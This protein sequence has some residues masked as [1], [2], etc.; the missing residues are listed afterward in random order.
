MK[1]LLRFLTGTLAAV[2]IILGLNKMTVYAQGEW[3]APV[4]TN[5]GTAEATW[6]VAE[7]V[8]NY[9]R[10]YLVLYDNGVRISSVQYSPK[11]EHFSHSVNDGKISFA[12]G[13]DIKRSG[14]YTLQII[15]QNMQDNGQYVDADASSLVS[16][17]FNYTAPSARLSTPVNLR[18]EDTRSSNPNNNAA[19]ATMCCDSV[20]G[21]TDYYFD[22]FI[23]G[24]KK[25][26]FMGERDYT[27]NSSLGLPRHAVGNYIGDLSEHEY[28]FRVYAVSGDITVCQHSEYSEISIPFGSSD[29]VRSAEQELSDLS[30]DVTVDTVDNVVE[31]VKAIEDLQIALQTSNEAV[32]DLENIEGKYKDA[33][34]ITE[35]APVSNFEGISAAGIEVTGAALN[36]SANTQLGLKIDAPSSYPVLDTDIYKN[37]IVFDM[38]IETTD[39]TDFSR[40]LAI[41]VTIKLPFPEGHNPENF[42]VLHFKA[43]GTFE[44]ITPRIE[45]GFVYIT[46]T[47]FSQFAFTN[48]N[49]KSAPALETVMMYRLYNPNSGE[50]F[51]TGSV[52]ERDYLVSLGWNFEGNAW[53]A[54]VT[55]DIPVFRLY[56][57]NA[58]D[59]H[60]TPSAEERDNLVNAGWNYEG[61]AWYSASPEGKPLHRLYNPNAVAGAHHYTMSEEERDNLIDLGWQYE[62]IGWFG[63]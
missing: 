41:P 42:R 6:T 47:H 45:G 63:A 10:M 31:E 54:P 19:F 12:F 32:Q 52:E 35:N 46:V 37:T 58:G 56:N 14:V 17:A 43:D 53:E 49:E 61:I 39:G 25:Y 29:V 30:D 60:Y 15:T 36:V 1:R 20:D 44:T 28:T 26:G 50:H 5:Y 4:W 40:E 59:H 3:E 34:S 2:I 21:A 9:D 8:E 22:F 23:D 16:E 24:Q 18:W 13:Q 38:G 7:G 11:E 27:T 57:P 55:S 62:G 51:Y 33:H 48:V